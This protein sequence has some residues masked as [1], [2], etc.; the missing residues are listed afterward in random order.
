MYTNSA[1]MG[2]SR[3]INE[4]KQDLPMETET[5]TAE[6]A[7]AEAALTDVTATSDVTATNVVAEPM[8]ATS[9]PVTPKQPFFRKGWRR[10]APKLTPTED[11][12]KIQLFVNT[13]NKEEATEVFGEN[14]HSIVSP[15]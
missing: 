7:P 3:A 15:R 1:P 14:S 9:A 5:P 10:R 11:L 8:D 12:G 2:D 13:A 4:V 6:A